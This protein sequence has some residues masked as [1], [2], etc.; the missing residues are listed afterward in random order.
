MCLW[1][2]TWLSWSHDNDLSS[3]CFCLEH[4][5]AYTFPHVWSLGPTDLIDSWIWNVLFCSRDFMHAVLSLKCFPPLVHSAG[6]LEYKRQKATSYWHIQENLLAQKT[7]NPGVYLYLQAWLDP[8]LKWDIS[9]S[10]IL[11]PSLGFPVP[12]WLPILVSVSALSIVLASTSFSFVS[13]FSFF[14][15]DGPSS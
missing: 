2:V 13:V 4:H 5:L 12:S 11:F 14:Y 9:I 8:E 10:L 3:P 1:H 15:L 6:L 7:A